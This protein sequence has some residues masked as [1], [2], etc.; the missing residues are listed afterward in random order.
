[1]KS[2]ILKGKTQSEL[3]SRA[4]SGDAPLR[5]AKHRT[6][7]AKELLFL[8]QVA[9]LLCDCAYGK[10]APSEKTAGVLLDST[11]KFCSTSRKKSPIILPKLFAIL[12]IML[13]M[14][15]PV[16]LA[17]SLCASYS[18]LETTAI[19]SLK[20]NLKKDPS[21]E[22]IERILQQVL[23]QKIN[24]EIQVINTQNPEFSIPQDQLNAL[25]SQTSEQLYDIYKKLFEL[26][27]DTDTKKTKP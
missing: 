6:E 22:Q 16:A 15:E 11:R 13:I 10:T 18:Q 26:N 1:M 8:A 24:E 7:G 4:S 27:T 23:L 9:L 2:A 14:L 21:K 5:K 3:E 12:V 19:E 20:K 17:V 25:N